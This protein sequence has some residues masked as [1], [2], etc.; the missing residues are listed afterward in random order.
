MTERVVQ[1]LRHLPKYGYGR[2]MTPWW[3][4]LAFI[5][6]EGSGF[7]LAMGANLYVVALYPAWPF[8]TP[9]AGLLWSSLLTVVLLLSLI[10]NWITLKLAR[11]EK[12]RPV[13]LW[14]TIMSLVGVACLALRA[15]E[16]T[17]LNVL[18]STNVYGSF[19]W[20]LLGLHTTHIL[21][22]V[23]DTIVLNVLMFTSHGRGRR[24]SDV[25]DNAIYW[26]FV[27]LSWLPFYVVLY[28]LPRWLA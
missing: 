2:R 12:L 10:P 26:V 27:V 15:F 18:W 3:G 6:I 5:I 21:T 11:A 14:L 28:W 19:V 16:F 13:R 24:F 22:D 1:D 20:L 8:G 23:V 9:L 17:T 7:A 4:T 25:E